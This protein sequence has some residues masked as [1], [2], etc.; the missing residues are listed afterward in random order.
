MYAWVF[1]SGPSY[2]VS[3]PKFSTHIPYLPRVLY[4]RPSVLI[5]DRFIDI[6]LSVQIMNITAFLGTS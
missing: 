6:W 5:F 2:Q 4:V 3:R 1:P